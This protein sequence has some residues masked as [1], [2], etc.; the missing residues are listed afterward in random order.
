MRINMNKLLHTGPLKWVDSGAHVLARGIITQQTSTQA[1]GL[2]APGMT[3]MDYMSQAPRGP[4]PRIPLLCAH[5]ALWGSNTAQVAPN[6]SSSNGGGGSSGSEAHGF[7]KVCPQEWKSF[8]RTSFFYTSPARSAQQPG[9]GYKDRTSR[10]KQ[11]WGFFSYRYILVISPSFGF[12]VSSRRVFFSL[13]FGRR[14][15]GVKNA[16]LHAAAAHPCG[17][18]RG[19]CAVFESPAAWMWRGHT[20]V[21]PSLLV[22]WG[23]CGLQSAEKGPNSWEDPGMDCPTVS[24]LC[25]PFLFKKK[26]SQS[27]IWVKLIWSSRC[28]EKF[29]FTAS[30]QRRWDDPHSCPSENRNGL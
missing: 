26:K 10:S 21:P 25:V 8:R 1:R 14:L 29:R 28:G 30:S 24:P 18:H 9:I 4:A 3:L 19:V 16:L 6:S 23:A 2:Q 27:L 17:L 7:K 12:V 20:D 22:F 13:V 11:I 5:A 15:W